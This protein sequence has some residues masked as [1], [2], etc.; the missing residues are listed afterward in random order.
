MRA[1]SSTLIRLPDAP[2]C[3][4]DVTILGPGKGPHAGELLCKT[5]GRHRRWMPAAAIELLQKF[6]DEVA[7]L[8]P[9]GEMPVM[10]AS[11]LKIGDNEMTIPKTNAG[12]LFRNDRKQADTHPDYNGS[13]DIEGTAYW[14]NAWMKTA[15]NG[16]KF[17][18]LSFKRKDESR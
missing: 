12:S 5:C 14:I 4:T 17:M 10:R 11:S 2:C 7:R 8:F 15:K 13:V 9:R 3:D 18:S 1:M 6:H 16:T